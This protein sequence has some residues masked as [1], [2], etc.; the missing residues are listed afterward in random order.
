M[1]KPLTASLLGGGAAALA[2]CLGAA[3]AAAAG[4][5][6]AGWTVKP[7]GAVSFAGS[8]QI[9]DL[10]TGTV[11]RCTSIQL[12]GTLKSGP[13]PAIG[14]ITTASV[15]GCSIT[16]LVHVTAGGLPWELNALHYTKVTGVTTGTIEDIDLVITAP[17]CSAT[18]DGT[19][20]G[21]NNGL[22]HITYTNSTGKLKLH[23][24]G[25]L[26]SYHVSGCFG[27]VNNGDAQRLSGN[28]TVTPQQTITS[29]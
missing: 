9:K 23:P 6:H 11:A 27:L 29:P 24:G 26:H 10:A 25:N 7:G 2:L 17:G 12:S 5:V 20:A 22:T 1:R 28:G 21:A 4:R 18:L 8:A 13:G 16:G 19:A 15:T 3:T 14:T